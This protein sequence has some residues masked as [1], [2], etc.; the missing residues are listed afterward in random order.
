MEAS[1]YEQI[2]GGGAKPLITAI[3][4]ATGE[5]FA[6][7]GMRAAALA[8]SLREGI[9]PPIVGLAEPLALLPFVVGSPVHRTVR[10]GVLSGISFG[11]TYA[12]LVF[13]HN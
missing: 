10:R 13:E 8:L 7:G 11:G 6:S 12:C 2:F 3:K 9:V 4:G 1:A 5:N